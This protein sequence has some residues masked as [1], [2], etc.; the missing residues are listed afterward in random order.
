M[1]DGHGV[2]GGAVVLF[3]LLALDVFELTR[4]VGRGGGESGHVG[5]GTADRDRLLR[6]QVVSR[7]DSRC[8]PP[9]RSVGSSV[10]LRAGESCHCAGAVVTAEVSPGRV[11]AQAVA[12]TLRWINLRSSY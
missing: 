3:G 6:S 9:R 4:T 5:A 7:S 1:G 8:G 2:N 11:A 12:V 10:T